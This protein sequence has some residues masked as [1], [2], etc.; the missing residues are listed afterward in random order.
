MHKYPKRKKQLE[1]FFGVVHAITQ[2]KVVLPEN[3]A[4]VLRAFRCV[5]RTFL[6]GMAVLAGPHNTSSYRY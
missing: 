4:H 6:Y 2:E 3:N 1:N 5:H